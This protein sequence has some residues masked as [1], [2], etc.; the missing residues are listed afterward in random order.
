MIGP[1]LGQGSIL[2]FKF[3]NKAIEQLFHLQKKM[4]WHNPFLLYFIFS[5]IPRSKAIGCPPRQSAPFLH[6]HKSE[7]VLVNF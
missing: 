3:F 1:L 6:H 4:I 7:L 5:G 2:I